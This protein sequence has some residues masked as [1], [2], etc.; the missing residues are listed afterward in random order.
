MESRGGGGSWG[1]QGS[2]SGGVQVLV[3]SRGGGVKVLAS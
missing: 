2:R 3:G 1:W